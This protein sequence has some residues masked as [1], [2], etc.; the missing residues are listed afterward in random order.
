MLKYEDIL[1]TKQLCSIALVRSFIEEIKVLTVF[2]SSFITSVS[3]VS[4]KS[5]GGNLFLLLPSYAIFCLRIF[6]LC[7]G[8]PKE[9][10]CLPVK[11]ISLETNFLFCWSLT[12]EDRL[13][14]RMHLRKIRLQFAVSLRAC[15]NCAITRK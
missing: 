9:T 5:Q 14:M 10:F 1:L 2:P 13:L 11:K 3:I 6:F 7:Y 8:Q 15:A 12:S 4:S